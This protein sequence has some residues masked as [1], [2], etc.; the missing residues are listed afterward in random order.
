MGGGATHQ[1]REP[2]EGVSV[3]EYGACGNPM[4]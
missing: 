4:R 2:R 3:L 1:A